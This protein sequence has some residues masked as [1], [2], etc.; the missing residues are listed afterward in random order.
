M[1]RTCTATLAALG[2]MAAFLNAC[3]TLVLRAPSTMER[4]KTATLESSELDTLTQ[5]NDPQRSGAYLHET[6]LTPATVAGGQFERLFDWEVDG[7]I[8]TQPLYVSHVPYQARE[9]NL[10]VVATT[11]NSIYAF[12]AP[13]ADGIVQ[14]SEAPLWH[15]GSDLLGKPLP[16]DFFLIDWGILGHNMK[17]LI[18][19]A[20]TPVIDRAR[21]LVYVTVKSGPGGILSFLVAPKYRLF[22]IDLVAGKIVAGVNISASYTGRDGHITTFDAKH[23]LQRA[24]LLE[25]NDRIY[26]AFGSHQDTVPYHGWVLAYDAE[27]LRPLKAYC[28]TCDRTATNDCPGDS[29]RGGIW[30]AGAGPASDPD[31]HVYVMS[32]NGGYDQQTADRGTSFIKF[33]Q[34]LN[35]AGSWTPAP[36]ACLN[37]TDADLGSAGPTYLTRQ[38]ILVGGGKEG[39]LYA[40]GSNALQG[41]MVQPGHRGAEDP[42]DRSDW[43]PEPKSVGAGADY[44]SIQAAPTWHEKG[45]MDILRKIDPS[46]A[47]QG[48]HHIHGSPVQWTAHTPTGDR[49]LLYV[50]A[51]RD[52]LRAFEFGGG[53]TVGSDPGV[54]PTDTFH[55]QCPNS[56]KGMP[57]GFLT[58]S[59]NQDDPKSGIVWV[60]M[61]RRDKDA[62]SN[63][64][65]GLLRAYRAF[66][67]D[68]KVLKEIWN[69]DNG[70]TVSGPECSDPRPSGSSQ[71]GDFAKFVS[72]T[73]AEGKVYLSTFSN[74]LVVYGIHRPSFEAAAEALK[75]PYDAELSLAQLPAMIE[76]GSRIAVSIT[77]T[78]TGSL[79]W[80]VGDDIQLGS[81]TAP[82]DRIAPVEGIDVLRLTRDVQP[83][84]S[85]VFAFHLRASPAEGEH[86]LTWRLVRKAS[87]G[88][89]QT[90][91]WFGSA[92]EEWEFN[93]L[94]NSC[95]ELRKL[96]GQYIAQLRADKGTA[97]ALKPAIEK[98]KDAAEAR[99][100]SLH[101]GVDPEM[102]H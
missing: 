26:L 67:D 10:I 29:C 42:C 65:R 102:N 91:Q 25:A 27:T 80:L 31:G 85:Y 53:F 16:F 63:T 64:V 99:K 98:L 38:S 11:N 89:P 93:T 73:V 68:G 20:S 55:S 66:P 15:V 90:R 75:K 76:P 78:N 57:G 52:L 70:L 8:Y 17:P 1:T 100:C 35:I 24:S 6:S 60:S 50:S 74:R 72:P 12:E 4:P 92:T 47:A 82:G 44:W 32:G 88:Q 84:E 62:L 43:V 48:Y 46:A 41:A 101:W 94:R 40:L 5:H 79:A 18:G 9:I 95:K 81:Q 45:V 7:Q 13:S 96:A 22:A 34:D 51:E 19:I 37:R 71:S 86:N 49:Q 21:G 33:D 23:H 56:G 83:G 28:T 59:A 97:A 69:S 36:Y 77:A 39:V 54:S 2:C 58:I 87:S 30:Q 61:P 3:G 14:P